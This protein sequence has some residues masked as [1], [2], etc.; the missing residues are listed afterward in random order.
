MGE[1]T[2]LGLAT[3]YGIVRQ[4]GGSISVYSEVGKGSIFKVYFPR[5]QEK[6][7]AQAVP[8]VEPVPDVSGTI[9]LVEDETALR[10]VTS[11]YLRA[12]GYKIVEARNGEAALEIC[13]SHT[14]PIDLLITDIVM[15]GSSGPIVAKQLAEMRPGL[16]TIYT[17]GYTDRTLA[18]G[19]VGPNA[20]FLQKPFNLDTLAYKIQ[21]MLNR[22]G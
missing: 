4:S 1:G 8:Q 22:E 21:A 9:L 19:L 20:V 3:V 15:P 13:R 7:E 11:E 12:K 5:V 6:K 16:R 2:G 14:G 18:P 17:S 10:E